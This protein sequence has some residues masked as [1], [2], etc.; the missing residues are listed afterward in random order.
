MLNN[1]SNSDFTPSKAILNKVNSMLTTGELEY[2]DSQTFVDVM[3]FFNNQLKYQDAISL[4]DFGLKIHFN[5][6]AIH[7]KKA[8][9]YSNL[10]LIKEA[11]EHLSLAEE[12][13]KRNGD[14][15]LTKG[16]LFSK[17]GQTE[18]AIGCYREAVKL[19]EFPEDAYPYLAFELKAIGNFQEA[20]SILKK[21]LNEYPDD[22]MCS[23]MLFGIYEEHEY[24]RLGIK[25]YKALVDTAPFNH[26]NWFYLGL[27]YKVSDQTK[28]AYQAFEYAYLLDSTFVASYHEMANILI[29]NKVYHKAIE[30]LE[31]VVE[32]EEPYAMTFTKLAE[33]Y[34][35]TKSY[36]LSHKYARK[37][38]KEDPQLDSAWFELG[39]ILLKLED[40]PGAQTAFRNAK[41][42]NDDEFDY[43]LNYANTYMRLK[44][45]TIAKDLMIS[46]INKFGMHEG[47]LKNVLICSI[48]IEAHEEALTYAVKATEYSK[49][50]DFLYFT[51]YFNYKLNNKDNTLAY[52]IKALNQNPNRIKSLEILMKDMFEESYVKL[53]VIN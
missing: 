49:D 18:S 2:L 12:H 20:I 27:F 52:L 36:A 45:W 46:I 31:E 44:D 34:R 40:F 51:A 22:E 10:N 1:P 23:S 30:I 24:Y 26:L 29:E 25:T 15:F 3:D 21:Y 11:K 4:G 39:L 5:S 14:I 19:L 17:E 50:V 43:H 35:F 38:V 48:H 32:I 6:G 41:G 33:L 47:L 42:L 13:D 53:L 9:A 7:L 16:M 8:Q 28:L 37:A